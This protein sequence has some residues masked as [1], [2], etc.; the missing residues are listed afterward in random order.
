MISRRHQ[1]WILW[2]LPLFVLRAF[3]PLGFMWSATA[4]GLQLTL[5]SGVGGT[6]TSQFAAQ[7]LAQND[8]AAHAH[9]HHEGTGHEQ[10]QGGSGEAAHQASLCPFAGAGFSFIDAD[11]A[12]VADFAV[13]VAPAIPSLDDPVP[14]HRPSDLLRIRGPPELT[15]QA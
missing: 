1:R 14:D 6:A 11:V 2:L 8:H 4:E 5:C 7:S 9:H 12:T 3:V 10:H 15:H 13:G